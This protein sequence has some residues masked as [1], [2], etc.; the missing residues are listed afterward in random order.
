MEDGWE[1]LEV[2]GSVRAEVLKELQQSNSDLRKELMDVSMR[3]SKLEGCAR[4]QLDGET[5]IEWDRHHNPQANGL[6]ADIRREFWQLKHQM[7]S[8]V[9]QMEM[10]LSNSIRAMRAEL[11][12]MQSCQMNLASQ[13]ELEEVRRLTTRDLSDLRKLV[14]KDSKSDTAPSEVNR[15]PAE[16]T[17]PTPHLKAESKLT[18]MN[19]S[20]AGSHPLSGCAKSKPKDCGGSTTASDSSP[21]ADEGLSETSARDN[22]ASSLLAQA[23]GQQPPSPP[24]REPKFRNPV[25]P[26]DPRS[27]EKTLDLEQQIVIERGSSSPEGKRKFLKL[28]MKQA[29]PDKGGT[30]EAVLW[31][32]NWISIHEEWFMRPIGST[33]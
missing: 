8:R 20:S 26:T 21:R 29:H 22:E 19:S 24:A 28:L 7:E 13:T 9:Q 10:E 31:L 12:S 17:C 1:I 2:T 16:A 15:L 25:H 6:D 14:L 33:E 30:T 3:L 18:S 4:H 32:R 5:R 23:A 11:K 27:R